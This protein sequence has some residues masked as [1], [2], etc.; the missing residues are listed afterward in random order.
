[1]MPQ[2]LSAFRERKLRFDASKAVRFSRIRHCLIASLPQN[3]VRFSR[4]V[5]ENQGLTIVAKAKKTLSPYWLPRKG[6]EGERGND[7]AQSETWGIRHG[8][9]PTLPRTR[10]WL[11]GCAVAEHPR[12]S[13][14]AQ[15]IITPIPDTCI[16]AGHTVR[17]AI[18]ML[19]PT[20][21]SRPRSS[22]RCKTYT[23]RLQAGPMREM[24]AV[25]GQPGAGLPRTTRLTN[26]RLTAG[27]EGDGHRHRQSSP[28][29]AGLPAFQKG[30]PNPEGTIDGTSRAAVEKLTGVTVEG[31][32]CPLLP[33]A[34]GF[35]NR[36]TATASAGSRH[37]VR[38]LQP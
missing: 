13:T 17:E 21:S 12:R 5:K 33:T 31:V 2:K 9:P 16:E 34:Q 18:G 30:V 37:R 24:P 10:V 6:E 36:T 25:A 38:G 7:T 27:R 23:P 35:V 26:R 11:S 15:I 4:P 3:R 29:R 1:M 14:E 28:R 8:V 22:L 20:A 32:D 19:S